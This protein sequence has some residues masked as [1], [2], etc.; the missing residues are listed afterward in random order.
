[1]VKKAV[2][3]GVVVERNTLACCPGVYVVSAL[4]VQ[5]SLYL[6]S[7]FCRPTD[8]QKDMCVYFVLVVEH[9]CIQILRFRLSSVLA[10]DM[11]HDGR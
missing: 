3:E 4:W 6:A 7:A 10:S 1:L 2:K 5:P 11:I 8:V 9:R